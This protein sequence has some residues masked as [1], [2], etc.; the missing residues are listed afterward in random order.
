VVGGLCKVLSFKAGPGHIHHL[1]VSIIEFDE[2]EA[3]IS[4]R[5]KELRDLLSSAGITAIAH[6]DFPVA[7]W[8]KMAFICAVGGVTAVTRSPVG[9]IRSLSETRE[10]IERS[11]QETV[12]VAQKLGV[13]LPEHIVDTII[14]WVDGMPDSTT[15]L[16]RDIMEGR[17]SEL[18][19]LVGSVASFGE[20]LGID[21]PINR[22]IYHSLL[23]IELN[24]R[25][26]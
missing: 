17:P 5:V 25:K 26:N 16:Q 18:H 24:A 22:F 23:P 2:M 3:K 19:F 10:L 11:L 7:L 9:T 20:K 1:G 6:D 15:S 12:R 21:V 4:H 13:N 14:G 8:I